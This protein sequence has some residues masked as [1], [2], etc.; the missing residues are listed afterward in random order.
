MGKW[1]TLTMY[2]TDVLVD[3]TVLIARNH[4]WPDMGK[5]KLM[6][7]P[8]IAKIARRLSR[9][10]IKSFFTKLQSISSRL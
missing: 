5:L 4:F 1:Y 3:A 10:V 7:S 6:D 2:P 9:F 8:I